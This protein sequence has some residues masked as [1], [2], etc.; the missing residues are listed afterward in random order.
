M[1]SEG[2]RMRPG[3]E[4]DRLVAE[5]MGW[6]IDASGEMG[7]PP[8]VSNQSFSRGTDDCELPHYSTSL[9]EVGPLMTEA[10]CRRGWGV[11]IEIVTDHWS[12]F[13]VTVFDFFD[14]Y[15]TLAEIVT[16]VTL[17]EALAWAIAAAYRKW[18]EH[19]DPP[20]AAT[21]TKGDDD[22]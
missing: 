13:T 11:T 7:I 10:A 4:L 6:K 8:R 1:A 5:V 15:G 16:D 22:E 20:A 14:G 3:R 18:Q 9:L 19:E 2:T 12:C 21:A 17:P